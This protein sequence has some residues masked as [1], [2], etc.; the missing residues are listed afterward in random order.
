M[1]RHIQEIIRLEG[2]NEYKEGRDCDEHQRSRHKQKKRK[3]RYE[4]NVG[5]NQRRIRKKRKEPFPQGLA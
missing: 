4:Q 3:Q 1:S 2:D 5:P